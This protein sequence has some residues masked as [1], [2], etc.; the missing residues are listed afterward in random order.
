M[1]EVEDERVQRLVASATAVYLQRIEQL[2]GRISKLE[3]E[4]SGM[5]RQ[6]HQLSL[7]V[8]DLGKQR[9]EAREQTWLA[10]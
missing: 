4:L 1:I 8:K 5:F 3:A 7:V 10:K 6:V 2:N 9:R